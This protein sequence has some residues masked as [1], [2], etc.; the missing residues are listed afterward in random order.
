MTR[1]TEATAAIAEPRI[2]A[3][4]LPPS[5]RAVMPVRSTVAPVASAAGI[6]STVSDPGAMAFISAAIAGVSGPWSG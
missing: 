5:S 3:R 4:P 1:N 2:W 6:R